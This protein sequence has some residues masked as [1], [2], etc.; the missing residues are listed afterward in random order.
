MMAAWCG[1]RFHPARRAARSRTGGAACGTAL[2]TRPPTRRPNWWC[3]DRCRPDGRPTAAG[4]DVAL[5]DVQLQLPPVA[6]IACHAP[7]LQRT[8]LVH[9]AFEADRHYGVFAPRELQ[10][11]FKRTELLDLVAPVVDERA[12]RVALAD[13]GTEKPEFG[14]LAN[15]Q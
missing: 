8:D 1:R 10:R 15:N 3:R 5:A 4:S 7:Q 13:R 6:S 11:D 9:M 2:R 14:R 12:R